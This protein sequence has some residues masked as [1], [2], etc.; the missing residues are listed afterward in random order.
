ML[1]NIFNYGAGSSSAIQLSLRR[2][3]VR[4]F[5]YSAF[6]LLAA[7][8]KN[9]KPVEAA[10]ADVYYT[11]SMHPQIVQDKPGNCPICHMEL[12]PVKKTNETKRYP[13]QRIGRR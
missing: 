10:K 1:Q 7:A 8:C 5:L 13:R 12:I 9:K 4:F 11:C 6:L 2:T 3:L